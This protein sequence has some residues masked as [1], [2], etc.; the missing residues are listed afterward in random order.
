[1]PS[2]GDAGLYARQPGTGRL[3]IP[4][5]EKNFEVTAVDPFREM[6]CLMEKIN[7]KG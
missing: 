3:A 2:E 6:L 7:G 5:A 1:M 4:L